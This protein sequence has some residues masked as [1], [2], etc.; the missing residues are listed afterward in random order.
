MTIRMLRSKLHRAAITR[1]DLDYVGSITIPTDLLE[2]AGMYPYEHVLVADLANGE[3]F[4][5]YILPGPAG[6]G[7]IQVNGA[8]ARKVHVG[9]RIIVMAF[10][11]VPC[12]PPAGWD[13]RVLIMDEHNR[14][15]ETH[16]APH[17]A[18][19]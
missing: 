10:C 2:T 7:E 1:A 13:P 4:E 3:R 8:A 17:A 6:T 12:P 18:G 9:D 15:L 16:G 14:V 5:T 19:H 11:D